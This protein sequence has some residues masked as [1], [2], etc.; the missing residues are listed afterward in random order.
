MSRILLMDAEQLR[1]KVEAVGFQMTGS[2]D[3]TPVAWCP[4]GCAYP[5]GLTAC[6]ECNSQPQPVESAPLTLGTCHDCGGPAE[7]HIC[8]YC[9]AERGA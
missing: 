3:L 7:F 5:A 9:L 1:S 8:K 6:P 4:C 2:P